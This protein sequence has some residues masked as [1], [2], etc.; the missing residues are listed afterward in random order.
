MQQ[1]PRAPRH[2]NWYGAPHPRSPIR[3]LRAAAHVA[4]TSAPPSSVIR[5]PKRSSAGCGEIFPAIRGSPWWKVTA[6]SIRLGGTNEN[7]ARVNAASA[8]EFSR[9]STRMSAWERTFSRSSAAAASRRAGRARS[10]GPRRRSGWRARRPARRAGPEGRRGRYCAPRRSRS[11]PALRSCRRRHGSPR[12]A[13]AISDCSSRA[14]ERAQ[15]DD[16]TAG[17]RIVDRVEDRTGLAGR[18]HCVAVDAHVADTQAEAG[19]SSGRSLP[20]SGARAAGSGS[21]AHLPARGTTRGPLSGPGGVR[22]PASP[23]RSRPRA[24]VAFAR[25]GVGGIACDP[26]R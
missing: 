4:G 17:A 26:A 12:T 10:C 2:R 1:S 23:D 20:D 15:A 5:V 13:P 21:R 3:S 24:D 7:A 8:S 9:M 25:Q 19:R 18:S 22:P 16:D 14:G 11:G 6:R